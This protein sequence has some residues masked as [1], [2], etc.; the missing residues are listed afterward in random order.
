MLQ[1][2]VAEVSRVER[3]CFSNPWPTSAYRRELRSPE[4]NYYLVLRAFPN[5]NETI[6]SAQQ[7]NG[8]SS[9]RPNDGIWNRTRL[10]LLSFGRKATTEPDTPRIAGFAGMWI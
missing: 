1:E 7:Q 3:R 8:H 5:G 9:D 2:D 10:P 6:G 4:Q